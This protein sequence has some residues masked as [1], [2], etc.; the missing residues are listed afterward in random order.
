MIERAV[1]PGD[2]DASIVL[3]FTMKRMVFQKRMVWIIQK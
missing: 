2:I 1:I 3:P